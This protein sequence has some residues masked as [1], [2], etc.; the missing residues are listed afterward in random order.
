MC[1]SLTVL[2]QEHSDRDPAHVEPV[3]EV[4]DVLACDG[5]GPVGLLIFHHSLSHGGHHIIVAVSDLNHSICEA[6]TSEVCVCVCVCLL[7]QVGLEGRGLH[8]STWIETQVHL[9]S[10]LRQVLL[11]WAGSYISSLGFG[12]ILNKWFYQIDPSYFKICQPFISHFEHLAIFY[13]VKQIHIN[14]SL[15]LLLL[16]PFFVN[17][18]F[19]V[20]YQTLQ[21]R[22]MQQQHVMTCFHSY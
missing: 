15:L 1:E 13:Y 5:V 14:N 9:G 17:P 11:T 2:V 21:Y 18:C 3:Q 19:Y 4:L 20:N 6:K 8:G 7:A 10:K 12:I 22:C 16:Y